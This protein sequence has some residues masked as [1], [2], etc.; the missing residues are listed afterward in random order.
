[1]IKKLFLYYNT[2]K[3]LKPVQIYG[4]IFS[5]IK[6][7]TFSKR[8]NLS[9]IPDY[10]PLIS[11]TKFLNHDPWNSREQILKGEFNFLN[12]TQNIFYPP[13]WLNPEKPLLW[14]FNLHY[15]NYLHLLNQEE[16]E[17]IIDHWINHNPIGS[18]PGW[19]PYVIS[20][21][22]VSLLKEKFTDLNIINSIALQ[23]EFL[24]KNMEYYH[25][26]NHYLENARALILAGISFKNSLYGKKWYK[27]GKKIFKK[28]LP[29]EV[30]ED[31]CY[32]EKSPMYHNIILCG[33]LDL[34]N[35]IDEKI[36]EEFYDFIKHYAIKMLSFSQRIVFE[37]GEF[38]LFNDST[39]EIAPS[40]S[41][42]NSYYESITNAHFTVEQENGITSSGYFIF[43]DKGFEIIADFGDIGPEFIPAHAH[44]DIFTYELQYNG[45]PFVV[46]SGVYEYNAGELRDLCRS[47][48]AHNTLSIDGKNQIEMWG[49][50]R[51]GRRRNPIVRAV[52]SSDNIERIEGI[53]KGWEM[54]IGKNLIHTREIEFAPG[55]INI[56]D[57]V[58]GSGNHK[59]TNSIHLHPEV[60]IHK[61]PEGIR[62]RNDNVSVTLKLTD[63]YVIENS[64]FFPEFGKVIKRNV[65]R[66]YSETLPSNFNYTFLYN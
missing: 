45:K 59:V 16:K 18:N 7:K 53:F 5:L 48:L 20:L 41:L 50:F 31:G 60:R 40:T 36:D 12:N 58:E 26:A 25:P 21:R 64:C 14:R 52:R 37:N 57:N 62:L 13:N 27:K 8:I 22:I 9:E 33:L 35:S 51:V 39:Y 17:K 47:T 56:I 54:I 63:P 49:S 46:D 23:T 43:K 6:K 2:I 38:P 32:F 4:R 29:K 19:H 15:M 65:I 30:L 11:K 34:L 42:L 3:Y 1:M 61:V 24:Y 66:L 55:R 28:E 10:T 44:A